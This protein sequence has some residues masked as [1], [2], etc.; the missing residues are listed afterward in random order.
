MIAN[1]PWGQFGDLD[2]ICMIARALSR[3][4]VFE[5]EPTYQSYGRELD[6]LK[7]RYYFILVPT[8]IYGKD[9]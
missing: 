3:Q 6:S 9:K 7:K 4:T 2:S 1:S 5:L 8:P